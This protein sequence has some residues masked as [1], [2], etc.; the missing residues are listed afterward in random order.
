MSEIGNNV[1]GHEVDLPLN[2]GATVAILQ[3]DGT[4]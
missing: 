3:L 1:I 2:A 4:V